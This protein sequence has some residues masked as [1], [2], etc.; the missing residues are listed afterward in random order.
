MSRKLSSAGEHTLHRGG[1]A[2]SNPAVSTNLII[3]FVLGVEQVL[4]ER[5]SP[6]EL[7]EQR[8]LFVSGGTSYR[9]CFNVWGTCGTRR[10]I[11]FIHGMAAELA[12]QRGLFASKILFR[13][14]FRAIIILS[15]KTYKGY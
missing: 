15:G 4:G 13:V 11:G 14:V 2:G 6:A 12:E 3:P 5:S 9:R 1:V 7:A 10:T 8:G